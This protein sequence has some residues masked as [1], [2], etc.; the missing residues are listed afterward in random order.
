MRL[1]PTGNR[2]NLG[3]AIAP[4]TLGRTFLVGDDDPGFGVVGGWQVNKGNVDV[5]AFGAAFFD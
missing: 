1:F 2:R 5:F 4:A 3:N